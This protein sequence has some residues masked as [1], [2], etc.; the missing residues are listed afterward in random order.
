M[1]P[2]GNK[3][4]VR[5]WY[6]THRPEKMAEAEALVS[7]DFKAHMPGSPAP[8]DREAFKQMGAMFFSAFSGIEQTIEE[9]VAEGDTVASRGTWHAT[10]TGDFQGIPPTGKR[11]AMT[12]MGIDRVAGGKIAEHWAQLDILGIL[13]QLGVIPAPG[14]A[15]G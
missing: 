5:R 4:L 8:L 9:Q 15:A 13:Q 1:S 14:Q 2:E 7:G 10:H 12:W 3:V 6:D 11:V